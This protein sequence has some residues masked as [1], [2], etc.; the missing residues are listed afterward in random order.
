MTKTTRIQLELGPEAFK[1]LKALKEMTEAPSYTEV[2]RNS[3]RLYENLINKQNEGNK[4]YLK[5]KD[6]NLTEYILFV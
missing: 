4:V 3:L 1:R 5:D 2:V 6:G